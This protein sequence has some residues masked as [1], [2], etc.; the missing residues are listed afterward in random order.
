MWLTY[1]LDQLMNS[2]RPPT[3]DS[4]PPDTTRDEWR[5]AEFAFGCILFSDESFRVLQESMDHAACLID[6]AFRC[7]GHRVLNRPPGRVRD[8]IARFDSRALHWYGL[9]FSPL[10][11]IQ[12][13]PSIEAITEPMSLRRHLDE[14]WTAAN[15]LQIALDKWAAWFV[16]LR[17]KGDAHPAIALNCSDMA[18]RAVKVL[19]THRPNVEPFDGADE[20]ALLAKLPPIPAWWMPGI[21]VQP[22]A[23]KSEFIRKP[24][25][26]WQEDREFLDLYYWPPKQRHQ[27]AIELRGAAA[28]LID[29]LKSFPMTAVASARANDPREG[30]GAI[31]EGATPAKPQ[32]QP[33]GAAESVP[34]T[35]T[36][37]R[38]EQSTC[39]FRWLHL[40]DLHFGMPGQKWLWPNM[41]EEFFRDLARLHEKAGPWDLILFTGDFVQRGGPDEFAKL[42]GVLGRLWEKLRDLGSTPILLGVP[43]NHD[44]VRQ[45]AD[46]AAVASLRTG[47]ADARVQKEFWENPKS[48]FRKVVQKAFKNYIAWWE[49]CPLPRPNNFRPGLLP[50]DFSATLEKGGFKLGIVGLNTTFL[51]LEGGDYMG[52]LAL[53][54]QQFHE[55]CGGDGAAWTNGQHV[56]FLLTHHPPNWL[57]EDSRQEMYGEITIPGR[58]AVHLYGHMHQPFVQSLAVGGADPRREWQGCSL[59]GLEE[60]EERGEKKQRLHGYSAGLVEVVGETCRIC[61]WPRKAQRHQAQHLHIVP[62]YSFTLEDEATRPELFQLA[63]PTRL[64]R[65]SR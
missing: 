21:G 38:G 9:E 52:R 8:L 25:I 53:S 1:I 41:Q 56:C 13:P 27:K 34:A 36:H 44:L 54:A 60:W 28:R 62:D 3:K 4:V 31:P 18:C 6:D 2:H 26:R 65:P 29:L 59:F 5:K 12:P 17:E 33:G 42:N 15:C 57:M 58:F 50:G 47:W 39:S 7:G 63:V 16:E 64:F 24:H 11:L 22:N 30:R 14:V 10:P 40:T 23:E 35:E 19:L 55:A 48:D 45:K 51:Q 20:A 43:G 46:N 32:P 49:A 37:S 61:Q